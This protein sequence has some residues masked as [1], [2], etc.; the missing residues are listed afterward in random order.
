MIIK[1]YIFSVLYAMVCLALAFLLYRLGVPKNIT[2]KVVHILVG[3]EWVILYFFVGPGIHFLCVCLLF[4]IILALSHRNNLMP[5]ISSDSDNAPGTVYY[6]VAMSIMAVVTLFLPDMILPFGIGVFCTS[7]GDGFAGVVGQSVRASWNFRI[8]GNKTVLGSLTNFF[9]SFLSAYLFDV[10]FSLCMGILPCLA[11]AFFATELELFTGR[12]LDNIS[13][14]LGAA[15]LSY[16]FVHFDATADYIFP[17][18]LTPIVIV[19][20]YSKR[21][22]TVGG[23][24]AAVIV[25]L[26]ISISLGNFGFFAL[27]LFFVGGIAADKFKKHVKKSRQTTSSVKKIKT[28]CRTS[29]QVLANGGVAALCAVLYL[30]FDSRT[31]LVAFVASLAEALADTVASGVGVLSERAFDP[32]RMKRC[33]A[34][35]SGGMSLI[36]TLASAL[37]AIAFAFLS[38]AFGAITISEALIVFFAAFLGAVFDSFLGSLVQVKYKCEVCSEVLEMREHCG[39]PTR[40]CSGFFFVDNNTVNL[41]GTVFSVAFTTLVYNFI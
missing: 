39:M 12:G 30:I 9:L 14:T 20:A 33:P 36:G 18:L 22:L 11:I 13:I 26:I 4:L 34:G 7:V 25:D 19:F 8:Y 6:A 40:K 10:V 21:A 31:A 41:L 23:I 38:F 35:I 28:E 17:I 29:V 5:M 3:F 16:A 24:V 37:A 2:R 1:G 32:F 15:A 27:L